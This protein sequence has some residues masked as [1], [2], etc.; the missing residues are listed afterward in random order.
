M[1]F[2]VHCYERQWAKVR[3]IRIFITDRCVH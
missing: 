2:V 1:E 3:L